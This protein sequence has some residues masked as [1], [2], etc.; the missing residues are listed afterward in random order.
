MNPT[1]YT[2]TECSRHDE[3]WDALVAEDKTRLQNMLSCNS[4]SCHFKTLVTEISPVRGLPLVWASRRGRLEMARL[5]LLHGEAQVDQCDTYGWTALQWAIACNRGALVDLLVHQGGANVREYRN[6]YGMTCLCLAIDR[7]SVRV[8]ETLLKAGADVNETGRWGVPPLVQAIERNA[9][10]IVQLLIDYG[11]R[12]HQRD[13]CGETPLFRVKSQAMAQ[14]LLRNGAR[15][16][17]KSRLG[18]TALMDAIERQNAVV[19]K[20]LAE[21]GADLSQ[22]NLQ[23]DTPLLRACRDDKALD[24]IFGMACAHPTSL[25]HFLTSES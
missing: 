22:A 21:Q 3:F 19:A 9:T 11:A 12:I 16:N 24:M 4:S 6:R 14:L 23:G 1:M 25:L 7:S 5:L 17:D 15:V 10:D 18:E 13:E 8:V 2:S 20:A